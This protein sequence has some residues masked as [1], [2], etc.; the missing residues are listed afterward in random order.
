MSESAT[1]RPLGD[2]LLRLLQS[3]LGDAFAIERELNGGGMSRI[4]VAIDRALGRRVVVKLLSPDLAGVNM[5]RFRRE[6]LVSA[7][8][9]HPHIVPVLS[10]G[11]MQGVPY[12]T[13]PYLEGETLRTRLARRELIP[14]PDVV[15]ILHDVV[16]ALAHAHERG[17]VHR[18][19]KPDNILLSGRHAV[20]LDFG[21]AKALSESRHGGDVD[22]PE[23]GLVI[24]TPAYMAPEQAA[25]DP[26]TDHRADLY[27]FGILGYE[28]LALVPPFADRTP[29][30]MISAHIDE[31]PTPILELR[32]GAPPALA[33]LIMRCL[34]KHPG[35][36]PASA[37]EIRAEL[38]GIATPDI[39][40]MRAPVAA[41]AGRRRWA[42]AARRLG[43][44]GRGGPTAPARAAPPGWS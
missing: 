14:F 30:E 15:R 39:G 3:T 25:G 26:E 16:D 9:Q 6:I 36:R 1:A 35:D 28:M 20:V 37:A 10:A 32:P 8:L 17:I 40:T 44:C 19:I 22:E 4:F 41:V 34:E 12:Y 27:A 21:V 31:R 29:Q 2:P 5:D 18:D 33:R 42:A 38:E 24:G 7:G 43:R 11:E 13:M 23:I